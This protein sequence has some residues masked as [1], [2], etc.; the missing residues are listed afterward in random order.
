M[1]CRALASVA[2]RGSPRNRPGITF[3]ASFR[4]SRDLRLFAAEKHKPTS[5][6]TTVLPQKASTGIPG[7][8]VVPRAREILIRIY[9]R[10]LDTLEQFDTG[11]P[12]REFMEKA[13]RKRLEVL[14]STEDVF[15]IEERIGCGQIEE[16]IEQAENEVRLA[17][18][19][20]EHQPWKVADRWHRP[21]MVYSDVK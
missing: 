2:F 12:Y 6:D 7:L 5:L 17:P 4:H 1:L 10:Y 11:A 9:E 18:F 3:P 13:T 14:L 20:L 15:E 16:L 8:P 19:M 21:F